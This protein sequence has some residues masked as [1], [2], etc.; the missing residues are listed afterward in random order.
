MAI[1]L[2][3]NSII[4]VIV[5]SSE[6][7]DKTTKKG[8]F[9][10]H[11][12]VSV[13]VFLLI[14]GVM[15]NPL[16]I[17]PQILKQNLFS[18][19]FTIISLSMIAHLV[20]SIGFTIASFIEEDATN[21]KNL[22]NIFNGVSSLVCSIIIGLCFI[23]AEKLNMMAENAQKA[24]AT[25]EKTAKVA[26]TTAAKKET[27]IKDKGPVREFGDRQRRRN[28]PKRRKKRK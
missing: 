7:S 16:P 13:I 15:K 22:S 19:G 3:V 5:N 23:P 17:G 25:A 6:D 20:V 18:D 12:I 24:A 27:K 10:G 1:H 28:P 4:A 2:I 26:E 11:T 8:S 14:I 21:L 9:I